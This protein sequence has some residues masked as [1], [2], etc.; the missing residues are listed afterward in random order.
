[1]KACEAYVVLRVV[2]DAF[3]DFWCLLLRRRLLVISAAAKIV[4]SS[5]LYLV[6]SMATKGPDALVCRFW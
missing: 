2:E 4:K 6:V 3:V 5:A 1:M